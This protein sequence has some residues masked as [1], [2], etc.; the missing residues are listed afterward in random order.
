MPQEQVGRRDTLHVSMG[1]R[2]PD[3]DMGLQRASKWATAELILQRRSVFC[4]SVVLT[5]YIEP[6]KNRV[7]LCSSREPCRLHPRCHPEIC[8]FNKLPIWSWFKWSQDHP[9]RII[10]Q[11]DGETWCGWGWQIRQ[12]E[13]SVRYQQGSAHGHG[14][15]EWFEGKMEMWV[16]A[17]PWR[18]CSPCVRAWTWAWMWWR[19]SRSVRKKMRNKIRCT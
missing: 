9:W 3:I 13:P 2:D 11:T 16:S 4:R 18:P 1:R 8:V 14:A 12:E 19:I 15:T 6:V 5:F 10:K 7:Q 17:W